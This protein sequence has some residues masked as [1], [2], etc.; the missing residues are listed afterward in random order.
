MG[1]ARY[2]AIGDFY[3]EHFSGDFADPTTWALLDLA[4]RLIDR[5]VLDL[6]CGHGHLARE[7]ARR[8]AR[9][10]GVDLSGALLERARSAEEREPLGI[11]YVQADA[12]S[13]AALA[14]QAFDLVVAN[15]SL[16]DIDDLVGTVATIARVLDPAGIL[17]MSILHPCFAGG[18]E[19]SASWSPAATYRDEGWW[20]SPPEHAKSTLR[21]QVGANHRMLSTYLNA[22]SDVGLQ[23]ERAIE[24]APAA[25]WLE[26]RS[27][28][29]AGPV[30]L[31]ARFNRS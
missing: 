20:R 11:R 28:A 21:Q 3:A 10:V 4:G 26:N 13:Q 16:T 24:P 14:G 22:L 27:E 2:D 15:F 1:E 30:F 17:V 23:L 5:Q 9:V 31:V 12:A 18:G 19:V 25:S 7:M 29:S 6:G 8:G